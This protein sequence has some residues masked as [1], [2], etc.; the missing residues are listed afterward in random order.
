M[1]QIKSPRARGIHIDYFHVYLY[2][3]SYVYMKKIHIGR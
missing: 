1:R 3:K 2:I